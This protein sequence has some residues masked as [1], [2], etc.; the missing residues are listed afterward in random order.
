MTISEPTILD[1]AS[2]VDERI[3]QVLPAPITSDDALDPDR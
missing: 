3:R 1:P 2:A